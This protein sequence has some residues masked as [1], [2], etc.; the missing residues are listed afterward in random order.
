LVV[1]DIPASGIVTAVAPLSI[2]IQS[3]LY[4][5]PLASISR[6]LEFFDNAARVAGEA[7]IAHQVTVAYGDCSPDRIIDGDTLLSLRRRFSNLTSID[8]TFFDNNLG[9]ARGHNRLLAD[10]ASDLLVIANPDVLAAPNLLIELVGAWARPGTGFV[11]ARQLPIEHPKYYD[12][13]TGETSW[14]STACAMGSTKLFKALNGFDADT[15]FLYCD[16]VDFSWRVRLAGL[17][18]VHQPLAVVFHDKRLTN[19][20]SWIAGTAERYYSAEAG[21]LLPYKYSRPDLTDKYIEIFTASDDE[22]LVKA[23]GAFRLRAETG[24]LPT[25]IDP[26]HMVAEFVDGGYARSRYTPR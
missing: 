24:R 10:A 2:R 13:R 26:D 25:P 7:G 1:N 4:Q 15:F 21:L 19:E 22:H 20:G 16:D 6:A 9:S 18:V 23:A 8:Y 11:E 3:V 12:P 14:A 5:T 17:K